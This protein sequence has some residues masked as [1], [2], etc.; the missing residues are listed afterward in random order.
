MLR[1]R[2]A[3]CLV[4]AA[5]LGT[6]ATAASTGA[7]ATAPP[8]EQQAPGAPVAAARTATAWRVVSF[9]SPRRGWVMGPDAMM[10]TDDGGR[11]WTRSRLSPW[12]P[13]PYSFR[14]LCATG[15]RTAWLV[16]DNGIWHTDDAGKTWRRRATTVH[17]T[18]TY[19]VAWGGCTFVGDSVGWIHG[20][21]TIV[22][23]TDGGRTWSRQQEATAA[24]SGGLTAIAALDR[25]RAI[26][27]MNQTGGHVVVGIG[28]GGSGWAQ[29]GS[30]PFLQFNPYANPTISGVAATSPNT[31]WAGARSGEVF[32]SLN[33]GVDWSDSLNRDVGVA[34]LVSYGVAAVGGTVV[35]YGSAVNNTCAAVTSVDGG[36]SW[37]WSRELPTEGAC[38]VTDVDLLTPMTGWA[39]AGTHVLRTVDGGQS[40]ISVR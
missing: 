23:T 25:S 20:G 10:R 3:A 18:P 11:T 15:R 33:Q 37:Q 19:D 12:V 6:T 27:G 2:T 32:R 24:T 22:H 9:T 31:F 40:W 17:P 14:D 26:A 35:S 21:A 36:A 8:V 7:P 34:A 30:R 16:A 29:L 5:F 38:G 1:T 4:V 13:Q 39:A 28:L